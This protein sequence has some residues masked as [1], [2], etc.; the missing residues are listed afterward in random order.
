MEAYYLSGAYIGKNNSLRANI[1]SGK[2]ITYQAWNGVPAQYV[3][4][5]E[6]RKFNISGMEKSMVDPHDNEV[7]DYTQTHYQLLFTQALNRNWNFNLNGHYTR[8]YGFF[9]Q[10]KSN[11]NLI[12]DY[13]LINCDTC[14]SETDLIRR[15]WLDNDFY[16]GVWSL[17]YSSNGQNMQTTFG[18][19]WNQYKG[20]HYGEIIWAEHMPGLE[21]N[22]Q[23]YFG[24]GDKTDFNIYGKTLYNLSSNLIGFVDLQYRKV[25]Y[26]ITGTDNDL[27]A[28]NVNVDYNFFNPKFGFTYL[29]S[30]KFSTYASFAVANREPNRSD[31]TDAAPEVEPM[32]ER[33]YNTEAGINFRNK[34]GIFGINVYHMLYKDQLALTG[35]INDVG[36]A[37]RENIADSYR[38]G[39]ELSGNI[40]LNE[41]INIESNATFSKNKIKNFT[42]YIDNWDTWKQEVVRHGTT[43]LA[44]S[45]ELIAFAGLNYDLFKGL[46]LSLSGK[47]V[48]KQFIDNTSNKNT[49]LDAYTVGNFQVR[50]ELNPT[51]AESISFNLMVNNIFDKK[52][53]ANAWT[54]RYVSEG[55]DARPD[56]PYARSEGNGIYN[57]TG[58]Y[59][60]AGRHFLLGMTVEF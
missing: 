24:T 32:S 25:N 12:D 34:K 17:N 19:A 14:N 22:E 11:E 48:G 16:G 58:F 4:D 13:G 45:P 2:E 5:D 31:F 15:R 53:A 60:Q 55:Y 1:F 36:G 43:D 35:N 3:N 47:H 6:L 37:I 51:F 9:E 18:G 50:Y 52:Y 41:K 30:S 40:Y 21:Q 38:L 10:Y 46:S 7:D 8:G 59:P 42:E 23:Y 39:I 44:F 56:D 20:D 27:R 57:L 54:Y 28:T 33:L 29:M 49:M 26:K